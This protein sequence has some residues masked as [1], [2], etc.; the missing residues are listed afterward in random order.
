MGKGEAVVDS[1]LLL[2]LLKEEVVDEDAPRWQQVL[3][4]LHDEDYQ[5]LLPVM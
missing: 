4:L 2:S 3:S 1:C 5:L